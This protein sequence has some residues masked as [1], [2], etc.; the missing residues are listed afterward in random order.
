MSL[1][2]KE[3]FGGLIISTLASM[4]AVLFVW[5]VTDIATDF[6]IIIVT[7]ISILLIFYARKLIGHYCNFTVIF[8]I[9]SALYGLS[10]PV[11]ARYG[12]GLPAIFPT[13]YLIDQFL[14]HY[15]IAILGIAVG[16]ILISVTNTRVTKVEKKVGSWD[17]RILF[18]LA[19]IFA[20]SASFMELVNFFRVGGVETLFAGKATYQGAISELTGTLPSIEIMLLSTAFM[21]LSI[22]ISLNR[23]KRLWILYMFFWLISSFPL[24]VNLIILGG[25]G[26]LISIIIV[27]II[28]LFYYKPLENIKFKW[29][30]AVLILYVMMCFLYGIRAQI[31]Y[32]FQSGDWGIMTSRISKLD[33]WVANL[34]PARNEFGAPFGN[35]N[36]YILLSDKNELR[37]GETYF[38]G[39][40]IPI[41][42]FIWP[43]KPISV[44]Y[45]FRNKFFP[46]EA[47]RGAIA[48]TAYSSIL[49]A[50]VNFGTLGVFIV[51][52]FVAIFMGWLEKSRV[53][54]NSLFFSLFY[55]T[56]LPSA[57]SFHRSSFEM[58]FF[59][60]L[61]LAYLGNFAYIFIYSLF[62]KSFNVV[63]RHSNKKNVFR[64]DT[65]TNTTDY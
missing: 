54:N 35:F 53:K 14:L 9:F 13:P 38:R 12:E 63:K 48:G 39:L 29:I 65:P 43:D 30:I 42:R 34:N 59:W 32:F 41:P 16:L 31:G 28:G 46:S 23:P 11:T 36:T 50:Y 37:F 21:G 20:L 33:F 25:R 45:E 51:Y 56:L 58:P 49:E 24:I 7:V 47:R 2:L 17:R 62:Y 22:S 55:L 8:L 44:T 52:I 18:V 26:V 5:Q 19:Y 10:G 4:S 61:F 64:L 3:L 6:A 57:I 40:T 27:F 15:A 60:S 1:T